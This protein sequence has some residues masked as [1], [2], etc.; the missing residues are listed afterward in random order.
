MQMEV[1]VTEPQVAWLGGEGWADE[2]TV[3]FT[4][5]FPMTFLLWGSLSCLILR[6]IHGVYIII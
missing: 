5:G 4:L 6:D 2:A 3:A 1:A